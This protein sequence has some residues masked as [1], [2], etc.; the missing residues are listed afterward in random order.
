MVAHDFTY[1]LGH[2]VTA[3]FWHNLHRDSS[4]SYHCRYRL[5]E[6]CLGKTLYGQMIAGANIFVY[7][8]EKFT[9]AD[10][11]GKIQ[12]YHITSLCAPPTIYRFLIKEDISKYDLSSL[13]Y[14]T[15]AGEALKL[16]CI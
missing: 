16:F 2:I 12:D 6:S 15:T 1:P 5:G 13:E 10:I 14:C 9:P 7:D 11:L 8:H 4:S 3:S